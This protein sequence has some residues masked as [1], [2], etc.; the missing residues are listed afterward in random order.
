[1]AERVDRRD[2]EKIWG[3]GRASGAVAA[4]AITPG[5]RRAVVPPAA[6]RRRWNT[7]ETQWNAFGPPAGCR[8]DP[9]VYA[10][11]VA[12]LG[13][14]VTRA[15]NRPGA[16]VTRAGWRG[17]ICRKRWDITTQRKEDSRTVFEEDRLIYG[18][19]GRREVVAGR[20]CWGS[21]R[22]FDK[23]TDLTCQQAK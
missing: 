12:A 21:C 6:V 9:R 23:S 1:L 8:P 4:S 11:V 15:I 20:G 22:F 16:H 13:V 7:M 14:A 18:G 17:T 5:A 19:W 10:A 3:I 2:D